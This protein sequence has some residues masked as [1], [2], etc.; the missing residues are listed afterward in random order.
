[1]DELKMD[2]KNELTPTLSEIPKSKKKSYT[3]MLPIVIILVGTTIAIIGSNINNMTG[4]LLN[5]WGFR[6]V[7]IGIFVLFGISFIKS[8][9]K[10]NINSS[11]LAIV[12]RLIPLF[13]II[14][15]YS[16][17][18]NTDDI[19][20]RIIKTKKVP[21]IK[22]LGSMIT[23]FL[24]ITILFI[25]VPRILY[26]MPAKYSMYNSKKCLFEGLPYGLFSSLLTV[27]TGGTMGVYFLQ[28]KVRPVDE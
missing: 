21:I 14:S 18:I 1:M 2:K 27:L 7:A 3:E 9:K 23:F 8:T 22:I 28:L 20:K 6:A 5:V 26:I 24:I 17:Y 11:K 19:K 4:F 16:Y 13:V 25:L 10:E 12:A 15:Y